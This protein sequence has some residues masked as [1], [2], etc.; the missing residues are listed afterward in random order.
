MAGTSPRFRTERGFSRDKLTDEADVDR[1]YLS[2]IERGVRNPGIKMV[3]KLARGLRVNI[4]ELSEPKNSGATRCR[5]V[6]L[7]QR[8]TGLER[9]P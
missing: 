2:G 4:H 6:F 5:P 3:L 7:V 8:V 9:E 1:T